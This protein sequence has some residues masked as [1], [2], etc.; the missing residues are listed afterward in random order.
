MRSS[1]ADLHADRLPFDAAALPQIRPTEELT[2]AENPAAVSSWRVR[3]A[4]PSR[5]RALGKFL[6]LGDEKLYVR[7]V[8]SGTFR[9]GASRAG[10]PAPLGCAIGNQI[11]ASI[12]RWAGPRAIERFLERLHEAAKAEDPGGLCTYVNFPSTEYLRLGFVDFF[13]FNV[14]L[15]APESFTAY[16]ARLQNLADGRPLMLGEIGLDSRR[17]GQQAQARA[18]GGQV[19]AAFAGGCAGAFVFAWTDE[20]DLGRQRL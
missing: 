2:S 17:H 18:L 19:R 14:Y 6:F 1:P 11:P 4:R 8:T 12:V 20:W 10:R 16:L 3:A 5:P 15:E 13:C 9:P 7:G